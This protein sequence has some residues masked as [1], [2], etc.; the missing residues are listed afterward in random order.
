LSKQASLFFSSFFEAKESEFVLWQ[1]HM[2]GTRSLKVAS[3]FAA[4]V[5]G[6]VK[7]NYR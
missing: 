5:R 7:C 2:E 4:Q 3:L 1:E 6:W